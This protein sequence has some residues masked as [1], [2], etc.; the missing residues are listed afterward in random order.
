MIEP[1][2]AIGAIGN[3]PLVQNERTLE[4]SPTHAWSQSIE[5]ILKN[6]EMRLD[7]A[8]FDPKVS[9]IVQELEN[10]SAR[11]K[12]LGELAEL[13]LPGQFARIWA[14]NAEYGVPYLNATD[15]LSIFALGKPHPQRFLSR[16]TETDIQSLIIR[17][18]W[19]LMTCSGTIGRMFYVPRRLDGWAATHDLVR[20]KPKSDL[21]GYLLAWCATDYAQALI[22]CHTHGGQIDHITEHHVRQLLVPILPESEVHAI[23]QTVLNALAERER[24]LKELAC[25][26][27]MKLG[28]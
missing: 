27:P 6:P 22:H 25:V 24:A 19:L 10:S 14:Q 28:E 12:S 26:W 3:R 2:R 9:K 16:K 4:P 11:L 8:H 18:G 13:A 17:E 15:L 5:S 23:N 21:A 20:I 7:A 1:R